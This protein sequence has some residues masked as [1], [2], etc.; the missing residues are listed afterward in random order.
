[1]TDTA[2][3]SAQRQCGPCTRCC[4]GWLH[5]SAHGKPFWR[6]RPCHYFEGR[7]TIYGNHPDD[8]CKTFRCQW[9]D[10]ETIPSWMRPDLVNAILV[11][12]RKNDIDYLEINEAGEKLRVEV[13]SWAV[14]YCLQNKL[15]LYYT[16]DGGANRIGSKDFLALNW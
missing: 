16:V 2:S 6:G 4:E 1:M 14:M 12:R 13:L 3:G 5:G 9:L 7:C 10:N 8:P 15:N 11:K